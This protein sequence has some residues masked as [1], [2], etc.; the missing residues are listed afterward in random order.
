MRYRQLRGIAMTSKSPQFRIGNG[1][2]NEDLDED[3]FWDMQYL[4]DI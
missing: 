3:W 1:Y 4:Q 2:D